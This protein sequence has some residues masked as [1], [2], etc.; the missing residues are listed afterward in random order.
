M[1]LYIIRHGETTANSEGLL[2]G[3]TDNPLNENGI[4]LAE[5]TGRALQGTVFHLCY[6]S[7]LARARK[8]A[9]II[10]RE[11]GNGRTPVQTDER[12]K[13]IHM[14]E[15]E[16]K[17]F[18][19]EEREVDPEKIRRF[20]TN[21]FYLDRCPGGESAV[22][23]CD[24]TQAF[25]RELAEADSDE[26]CLIATHGFA[27]RAMLNCLYEN[28]KDFWHGHVPYNCTINIVEAGNGVLRL[29]EEDLV[30]YKTEQCIDRYA[31]F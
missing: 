16:K 17:R 13:E 21:P 26:N 29:L 27:L 23:V 11:S 1:R 9:E 30:L 24:R 2:Q 5:E 18:R 3:W 14:G 7:P 10:L 31:E 20:F 8:T 15:W 28:P 25:L 19:P 6:S 12:L 22:E 4:A